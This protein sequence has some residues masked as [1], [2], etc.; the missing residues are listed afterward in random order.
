MPVENLLSTI[1]AEIAQLQEARQ[2]LVGLALL[3]AVQPSKSSAKKARRTMSAE[4]RKHIAEGQRK[5][6]V[7][8]KKAVAK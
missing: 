4:A 7:A 3:E 8:Q 1:D 2:L 5:R 6:W